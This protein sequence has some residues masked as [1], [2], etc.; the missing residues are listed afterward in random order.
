M[1]DV[2]TSWRSEAAWAH[3][4]SSFSIGPPDVVHKSIYDPK[5]RTYLQRDLAHKI[6]LKADLRDT[7]DETWLQRVPLPEW[8]MKSD[9][10]QPGGS[11]PGTMH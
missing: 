10:G 8:R 4:L 9:D 3:V 1:I 6:T 5:I 7:L 11:S 2:P